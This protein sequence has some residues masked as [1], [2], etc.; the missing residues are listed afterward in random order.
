MFWKQ[1]TSKLPWPTFLCVET[2]LLEFCPNLESILAPAQDVMPSL[3]IPVRPFPFDLQL[4]FNTV[5]HSFDLRIL[6]I[7]FQD[8]YLPRNDFDIFLFLN[9][10]ISSFRAVYFTLYKWSPMSWRNTSNFNR[11]NSTWNGPSVCVNINPPGQEAP[12][13]LCTLPLP[14]ENDL[15]NIKYSHLP[16]RTFQTFENKEK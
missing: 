14:A 8:W 7:L 2:N 11:N 9:K 1:A 5:T 10:N 3:S 4:G 6:L 15:F 12:S 16:K 13:T